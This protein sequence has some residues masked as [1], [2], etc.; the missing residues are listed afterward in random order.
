MRVYSWPTSARGRTR[1]T[2][3]RN[4]SHFAEPRHATVA[5][6]D[7]AQQVMKRHAQSHPRSPL[8]LYLAYTAGHSPLQPLPE[9]EAAC[10]R[11]PHL[12]RRQYC[13]MVV[14][15]DEAVKNVTDTAR[16]VREYGAWPRVVG[17]SCGRSCVVGRLWS[18]VCGRLF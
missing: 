2:E 1:S 7:E 10:A 16:E 15:L 8:F 5:F 13:G 3:D 14:G 12:W 9:H 17:R 6:T 11:I 18:V 4:Y